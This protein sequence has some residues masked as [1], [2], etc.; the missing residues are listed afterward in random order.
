MILITYKINFA[1]V[2]ND[3]RAVRVM[4]EK[5]IVRIIQLPQIIG[6]DIALIRP[7]AQGD[8]FKQT[9]DGTL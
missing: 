3:E 9:I 8:I 2:D 1:A 6:I 5:V 4:M 7:V